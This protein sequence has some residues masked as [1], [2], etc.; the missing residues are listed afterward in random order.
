MRKAVFEIIPSIGTEYFLFIKR[1]VTFLFERFDSLK[2]TFIGDKLVGWEALNF[3]RERN[4]TDNPLNASVNEVRVH[5]GEFKPGE[6]SSS[7][8]IEEE[9]HKAHI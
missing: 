2:S 8:N 9:A 5:E 4:M 7:M 6:P 3:W 1:K